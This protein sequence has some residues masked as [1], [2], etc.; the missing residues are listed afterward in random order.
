MDRLEVWSVAV[1]AL[2]ERLTCGEFGD[3]EFE[4][5][6]S[7]GMGAISIVHRPT[8]EVMV[9]TDTTGSYYDSENRIVFSDK[10]WLM[11]KLHGHR[12]AA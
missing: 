1:E 8:R 4:I 3:G 11:E 12:R 6:V 5:H 9:L 7:D 10:P 2:R